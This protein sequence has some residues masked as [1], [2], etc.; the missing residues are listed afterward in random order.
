MNIED[1]SALKRGWDGYDALP[2]DPR[3]IDRVAG[4]HARLWGD[5]E[6]I[7]MPDGSVTLEQQDGELII[8][9]S[10]RVAT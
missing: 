8:E 4:M 5:W 3:V 1:L 2:I 6:I 9:L 7:P 10:I